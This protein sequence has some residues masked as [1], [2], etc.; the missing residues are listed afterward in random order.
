[1]TDRNRPSTL[2]HC[3]SR[4]HRD[5]DVGTD[6]PATASAVQ[7]SIKLFGP[8]A[9]AAKADEVRLSFGHAPTCA[10][11]LDALGESCPEIG[12]TVG[13]SRLAVNQAFAAPDAIVRSC[14]EVALI[15]L[16]GGG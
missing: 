7:I 14:D 9:H 8:Q 10:Q 12:P 6:T 4:F 2:K 5:N 3:T 16:L 1:M 11:V 13:S 15:G